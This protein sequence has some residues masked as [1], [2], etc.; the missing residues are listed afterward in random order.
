MDP[1]RERIMYRVYRDSTNFYNGVYVKVQALYT[2][3]LISFQNLHRIGRDLN[4]VIM[5]DSSFERVTPD[6]NVLIVPEFDGKTPTDT[7]L[8]ELAPILVGM[9]LMLQAL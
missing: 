8:I 2:S 3:K 5:I 4:K 9:H 1:T 6:E 7:S